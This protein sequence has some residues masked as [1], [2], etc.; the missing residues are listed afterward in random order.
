MHNSW[1]GKTFAVAASNE[2][3]GK[4]SRIRRSKEE[5]KSM[6]ESFIKRYQSANNGNFPSLNLTHK[7]VGGSFYT[8]REI[9]REIIQENRVL[10]P[11]DFSLE[12]QKVDNIA[13]NYPL[14][15]I[16]SEPQGVLFQT[17][18]GL[19][20]FSSK[21]KD[22]V[23]LNLD[24]NRHF[25]KDFDYDAVQFPTDHRTN[26][27][28]EDSDEL[29]FK[30]TI[31]KLVI[32]DN[33][34]QPSLE[35]SLNS[36]EKCFNVNETDSVYI[37]N[38]MQINGASEDL[39]AEESP[40]C[41]TFKADGKSEQMGAFEAKLTLPTEEVQVET[42]PL[43][44][45][46]NESD[47]LGSKSTDLGNSGGKLNEL[48]AQKVKL[49]N[50]ALVLH[51]DNSFD[52]SS[53]LVTIKGVESVDSFEV[54]VSGGSPDMVVHHAEVN[55]MVV[56]H[57][58]VN[59]K[60]DTVEKPYLFL[61]KDDTAVHDRMNQISPPGKTAEQNNLQPKND[62]KGTAQVINSNGTTCKNSKEPTVI[63]GNDLKRDG[64]ASV[65][66]SLP[67][68]RIDL[69]SWKASKQGTNPLLAFFKALV[70]AF[71]KIWSE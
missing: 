21:K 49:S 66:I 29:K 3:G 40:E 23:V 69:E 59:V 50:S 25:T 28:V 47:V 30:S 44:P 38:H 26:E 64:K 65:G 6:V 14:G 24:N 61:H 68:D 67:L 35:P 20:A 5:R 48:E 62:L 63:T 45:A 10:G 31:E 2:S 53:G 18:S 1:A 27:V 7:E 22:T 13:V 17:A 56:Q 57:G 12:E 42:F 71:V 19:N 34:E 8:V 41:E 46:T 54:S 43:R 16:S 58:E 15:T 39:L 33:Q 9:V 36:N 32:N 37:V 55:H 11:G 51:K 52:S 4:K 60:S 70:G